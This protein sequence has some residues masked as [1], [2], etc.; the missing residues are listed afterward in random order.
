MKALEE[1]DIPFSGLKQGH[2][3]FDFE[4]DDRFF[5]CFEESEIKHGKLRIRAELDRKSVLLVFHLTATG[6]VQ[7]PCDRCGD[8]VELA[9]EGDQTLVVKLGNEESEGEEDVIY[10]SL[11]DHEVNIAHQVYEM[12]VLA[13]PYQRMH[14]DGLCNS[15]A[16]KKIRLFSP[17]EVNKHDS[18]DPRWEALRQ[19]K[20]KDNKKKKNNKK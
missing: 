11:Q 16:L 3:V 19:L 7:V 20:E 2:H 4:V 9:I 18:V 8:D 12:I 15:E 13:V 14:P 5:E 6:T 10:L 17:D 1:F